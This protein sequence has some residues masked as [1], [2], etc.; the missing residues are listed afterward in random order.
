MNVTDFIEKSLSYVFALF[1]QKKPDAKQAEQ[2]KIIAHRGAH[3]HENGIIENTLAAFK[4]A[5][6]YGCWGSELD[7][8]FTKDEEPVVHHDPDLHRLFNNKSLIINSY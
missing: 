8:H 7:I 6:K 4:S 5:E 2:V 1:P 3:D